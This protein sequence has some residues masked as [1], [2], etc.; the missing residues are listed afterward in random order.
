MKYY[1]LI[2]N[3]RVPSVGY[4]DL[5][6]CEESKPCQAVPALTLKERAARCTKKKEQDMYTNIN[7]TMNVPNTNPDAEKVEYLISRLWN[8]KDQK[9]C[10]AC[11]TFRLR[12][13]DL[14][15]TPGEIVKRLTEGKFT[16]KNSV[17]ADGTWKVEDVY[18]NRP[19]D[20]IDWRT[21]PADQKGYDAYIAMMR[22][23]A[24]KV[25]DIIRILPAAE[26]LA[27]LQKFEQLPV[28]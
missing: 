8:I 14:P 22:D 15:K 6:C 4:I 10:E 21:E 17:N 18:H 20:Y 9:E 13:D 12:W 19:F 23:E 16:Y 27:A 1:D 26:G 2:D 28:Q 7:A 5:D 24:T 3:V 11:N 25:E